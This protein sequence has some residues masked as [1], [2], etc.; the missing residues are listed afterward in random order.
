MVC[1]NYI[2]LKQMMH[3]APEVVHAFLDHLAE[4]LIV[5]VCYQID[6]GAQ[7]SMPCLS[8]CT[9]ATQLLMSIFP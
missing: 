8:S 4:A 5:Y 6:S 9:V 7:A 1:R 2:E 3:S